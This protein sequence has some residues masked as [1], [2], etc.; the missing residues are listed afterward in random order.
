MSAKFK[1]ADPTGESTEI[2]IGHRVNPLQTELIESPTAVRPITVYHRGQ[3]EAEEKPNR[4]K[5]AGES[6]PT[7]LVSAIVVLAIH[8]RLVVRDF[9]NNPS[10]I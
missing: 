5:V 2:K 10:I 1:S 7:I 6:P 4:L 8:H 9:P 3:K